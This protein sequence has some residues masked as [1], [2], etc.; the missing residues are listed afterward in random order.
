MPNLERDCGCNGNGWVG[1]GIYYGGAPIPCGYCGCFGGGF[2]GEKLNLQQKGGL[3]SVGFKL[4]IRCL[5]FCILCFF[6]CVSFC[7]L[8]CVRI[9]VFFRGLPLNFFLWL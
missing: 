3:T 8:F 2:S 7:V 9:T 5:V 6:L 1:Q 4:Y